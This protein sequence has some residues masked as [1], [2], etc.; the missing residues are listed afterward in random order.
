MYLG[1]EIGGTKLQLGLGSGNGHLSG[2]WR[3]QVD[4]AKGGEG[5][6]Q[7]ILTAVPELIAQ[8]QIQRSEIRAVGIGF[9]GPV[10]DATQSVIES[11][12]I[13]GWTGFPLARWL[14]ESL[15]L[16]A[17]M[18][19]DADV[20]GLGEAC[21]GAGR[22]KSP[23]FYVTIGSGI[24]GGLILDGTILRGTGR[25]AAEIG[26]LRIFDPTCGE[27]RTLESL[28]SGWGI[29]SRARRLPGQPATRTALEVGQAA[30]AGEAWAIELMHTTC[31][32]LAEAICQCIAL[33]CPRRIVI[34]GGVSLM[35]ESVFFQPLR[36]RV[37][38]R[39]FKPFAGLTDIVPAE[40]GETVVVHGALA[41]ASQSYPPLSAS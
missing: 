39:V 8:A 27:Y 25:G 13:H 37:T 15:E 12:Q 36:E 17:V 34:G 5:I 40:L 14:G 32:Y 23:L 9:G 10:D 20:A 35:G 6:R 26:H 30:N 11:H 3:G 19:N 41:L 4:V 38:S 31:D 1:I 28:A 7:Q 18:G 21:F 2:L 29:E 16:P 22:G 24:G 33:V